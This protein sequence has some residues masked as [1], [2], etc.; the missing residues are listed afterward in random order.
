MRV[1][2]VYVCLTWL[3]SMALLTPR[4]DMYNQSYAAAHPACDVSV[5]LRALGEGRS[6]IS[7]LSILQA[8]RYFHRGMGHQD[9]DHQGQ[10]CVTKMSDADAAEH[11]D[12]EIEPVPGKFNILPRMSQAIE[13]TRHV[14]LDG[15][16]IKEIIPWLYYAIKID[17][18]NVEAYVLAS[19]YLSERLNKVNEGIIVL[20]EGLTSNPD[21]WQI[22]AELGR[23]YFKHF[24]NYEVAA[25]FLSRAGELIQQVPHDKFQ[26]RSVLS[27]LAYSYE[28]LG[29]NEKALP[30]YRRM[31]ELFPDAKVFNNKIKELSAAN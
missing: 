10:T 30:L 13:V 20:R 27:F 19:Y 9:E 31:H 16:Q 26:E 15:D 22:N 18:H 11:G 8:D 25:K 3:A 24:A 6:I 17:P 7:S 1:K 5:F 21:S 14:H 2:G 29:Q 28:G 23:I 12:R 4:I